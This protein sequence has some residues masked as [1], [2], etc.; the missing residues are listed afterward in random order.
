M[1]GNCS[2]WLVS[3]ERCTGGK[4]WGN[5]VV[6]NGGNR[7]VG[8]ERCCRGNNCCWS[9]CMVGN[10]GYDRLVSSER[11]CRGNNW[12]NCMV[13]SRGCHRLVSCEGK[14]GVGDRMVAGGGD[15]GGSRGNCRC[16]LVDGTVSKCDVSDTGFT[17]ILFSYMGVNM[18]YS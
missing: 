6:G 11:C 1:L 3:C 12:G 8:C 9:N 4:N 15:E 5:G 2:D 7:L 14:G 18:L 16:S 10:R 17:N 13:D